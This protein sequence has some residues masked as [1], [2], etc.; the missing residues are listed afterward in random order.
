MKTYRGSYSTNRGNSVSQTSD[1]GFIIAGSTG[2]NSNGYIVKTNELG[3]ILWDKRAEVNGL[4]YSWGSSVCEVSD[5][6]YIFLGYGR[7]SQSDILDVFIEKRDLN[8]D[9]VWS[10]SFGESPSFDYGNMFIQKLNDNILIC[11]RTRDSITDNDL[12]VCE[13][14]KNNGNILWKEIYNLP[15]IDTGNSICISSDGG[16]V[17][18]G[19]TDSFGYGGFDVL[20]TKIAREDNNGPNIPNTPDG[21]TNGKIGREYHYSTSTVDIDGDDIFFLFDWGNGVT[22]FILGPYASDEECS[23]SGTWFEEGNYEIRVKAIDEHGAESDWSD[24]LVISMPKKQVYQY[25]SI[26]FL[27]VYSKISVVRTSIIKMEI[28]RI[29]FKLEE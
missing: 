19:Y 22:S 27:D 14:D 20:M 3:N 18:V 1:G 9:V 15:G 24:P 2:S 12:Y 7:I 16:I 21:R 25:V 23:A 8:G 28:Q 10:N 26:D 4:V 29:I 11:G 5:N 6:N 13:I 17:V